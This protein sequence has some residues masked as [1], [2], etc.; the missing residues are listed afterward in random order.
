MHTNHRERLKNRFLTEG[1]DTFDPHNIMELLLFYSIPQ[2]DTN[3]LG[4]EL[5]NRFGSLAGV[6]DAPFDELLEVEAGDK[7]FS[8]RKELQTV[9]KKSFKIRC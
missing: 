6:F 5:I 7:S 2:R 1:L 9:H 4:H 3:E 8:I